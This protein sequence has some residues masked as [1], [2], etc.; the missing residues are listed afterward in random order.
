MTFIICSAF[1]THCFTILILFTFQDQSLESE[2]CTL[3]VPH[4]PRLS[5]TLIHMSLQK[6]QL[7]LYNHLHFS[8][9]GFTHLSSLSHFAGVMLYFHPLLFS[10]RLLLCSC[11]SDLQHV[12]PIF[13]FSLLVFFKLSKE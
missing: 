6:S 13:T 9:L 10:V 5:C 3:L 8:L 4:T 7:S 1:L 11:S 12:Y 2:N